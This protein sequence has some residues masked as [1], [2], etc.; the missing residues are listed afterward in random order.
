[1]MPK[2]RIALACV[3][4]LL[5]LVGLAVGG[6]Q[7]RWWL[8]GENTDRR[9]SI[10]NRNLGT[11]TAWRDEALDLI[12]QASL[13]PDS[14]P[15]RPALHRQA[16]DLIGRLTDPYMDDTLVVFESQECT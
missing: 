1:M 12:N 14:A 11:Q 4:A 10:E 5:L 3:A 6:Y 7:L 16:C 9:V 8:R 15:Q 13:L 2:V